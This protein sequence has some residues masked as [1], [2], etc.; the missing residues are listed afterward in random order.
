MTAVGWVPGHE[1]R[2]VA[3][4]TDGGLVVFDTEHEDVPLVLERP[5]ADQCVCAIGRRAAAVRMIGRPPR[6][7]HLARCVCP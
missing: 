4:F 3:S 1:T 5:V 2:A 6:L 7:T